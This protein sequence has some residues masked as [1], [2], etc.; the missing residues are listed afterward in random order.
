MSEIINNMKQQGLVDLLYI[1]DGAVAPVWPLGKV[2][3][4]SENVAKICELTKHIISEPGP[5]AI[6][7]WDSRLGTPDSELIGKTL[8]TPGDLWHAGLKLGTRGTPGILDF[9]SPTWM[10]NCDPDPTIKATSWRLSLSACLVKTEVLRQ[11]GVVNPN[12]QTLSGASLE[13]AHRF[14]YAGAIMRHVPWVVP[15]SLS[16]SFESVP[17]G[18]E[19][20][21]AWMRYGPFWAKWALM[22]ALLSK[23]VTPLAALKAFRMVRKIRCEASRYIQRNESYGAMAD[24]EPKVS[25]LIP[26]LDRYPYLRT[27]LGQLRNQT[28]KPY[29][30]LVVDQT[31]ESRRDYSLSKEFEDL[32]LHYHWMDAPGQCCSRNRG[33]QQSTGDYILFLDDDDEIEPDLIEKHLATL[34]CFSADVSSGIANEIGADKPQEKASR[35]SDVF[36]TNNTLL[37]KDVLKNSGLFDLA[38]DRGQ[39][40]DG[41]L[42]MR[43]CLSGALMILNPEI[44]VLHH[45][46]PQG[47]LRVHKARVS[48]YASSRKKIFNRNLPSATEIYLAQRYFTPRQVSEMLLLRTFGTFS[49]RGNLMKKISK[50]V[51]SFIQLPHTLWTIKKRYGEASAMLKIYPKIP[52]LINKNEK[53]RKTYLI[54]SHS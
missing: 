31:E 45:H 35:S 1:S 41:D 47:G 30:V 44:S 14:L 43:V 29:E 42:G 20:L 13:M 7:Y 48:T 51:V 40:A 10:L 16:S 28:V 15:N 36:P 38:Y 24:R 12:F 4:V 34:L 9:I 46:A 49:I 52:E 53:E 39:R 3:A 33:L 19:L 32:P 8:S 6:L 17:F 5:E 23:Y 25:I 54:S 50:L 2:Y 11:L 37:R 26:T 21:F 27:L 22:R 18:D